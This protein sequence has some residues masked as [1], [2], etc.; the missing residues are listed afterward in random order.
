VVSGIKQNIDGYDKNKKVL[1]TDSIWFTPPTEGRMGAMTLATNKKDYLLR[2]PKN[3]PLYLF[4][5]K[6]G[7]HDITDYLWM[8]KVV[9]DGAD[10]K[11]ETPIE[12][13]V[14]AKDSKKKSSKKSGFNRAVTGE[15]NTFDLYGTEIKAYVTGDTTVANYE[16]AI[17][18]IF[19]SSD[20]PLTFIHYSGNNRGYVSYELDNPEEFKSLGNRIYTRE[21]NLKYGDKFS[22]HTA[23]GLTPN[24]SPRM[25]ADGIIKLSGVSLAIN[26][27]PTNDYYVFIV[28]R[29]SDSKVNTDSRETGV[30][31][32]DEEITVTGKKLYFK[33][34][35]NAD[36]SKYPNGYISLNVD[37][38]A[39]EDHV[40]Y[41]LLLMN[42]AIGV[43]SNNKVQK[44]VVVGPNYLRAN[45]PV[46][47]QKYKHKIKMPAKAT[48]IITRQ[49]NYMLRAVPADD[50]DP[51][52]ECGVIYPYM[53]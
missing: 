24:V 25:V 8:A 45:N 15:S 42:G 2:V 52:D 30:D 38:L 29:P 16:P 53:K 35:H 43:N 20:E 26:K 47:Y 28:D 27:A 19:A 5:V 50:I 14:N 48:R 21:I 13:F 23:D 11:I 3:M 33:R 34:S 18:S 4:Q 44:T 37:T 39:C 12:E 51:Q 40:F 6:S 17:I 10:Y 1:A 9:Q 41:G 31:N 32:D 36:L 46:L 7:T 22:L 49:P